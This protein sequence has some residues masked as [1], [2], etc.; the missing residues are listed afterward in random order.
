MCSSDLDTIIK[1]IAYHIGKE[2]KGGVYAT[3]IEE[4]FYLLDPVSSPSMPPMVKLPVAAT[5]SILQH[6]P[7][8]FGPWEDLTNLSLGRTLELPVEGEAR[9]FRVKP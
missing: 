8:P 7:N 3:G 5:N 1:G 2:W 4:D 6:A 9:F